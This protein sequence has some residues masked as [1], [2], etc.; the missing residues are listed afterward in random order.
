[1]HLDGEVDVRGTYTVLAISYL[2]NILTPELV[3]GVAEW[4]VACQSYEG[5]FGGEEYNESHGGYAYCA[6]AALHILGKL[7]MCDV[8]SLKGWLARRQMGFEGGFAGRANKLVDGCYTFWQGSAMAVVNVFESGEEVVS[9]MCGVTEQVIEVGDGSGD[10]ATDVSAVTK[11][12]SMAGGLTYDQSLLQRYV[13]LCGQHVE[14]GLRDKPSKM[15]DY[16]HSCYNLSGLSISQHVMSED[17][18]P[19]VYGDASNVVEATHACFNIR[20]DRVV[21][22][23]ERFKDE[24]SDHATLISM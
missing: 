15:R 6:V 2:L 9:P 20:C 8:D 14:G 13:L 12:D 3:E 22:A 23:V 16:Y 24:V 18:K 19:V 21:K 10:E 17:G 7:G 1:M 5:G 11:A 4:I